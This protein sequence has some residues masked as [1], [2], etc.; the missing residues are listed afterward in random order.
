MYPRRGPGSHPGLFT[1]MYH[2]DAAYVSWVTGRNGVTTFDLY[3]RSAPF[4][5]A[6][7]LVAG[8]EAALEFVETFRYEPEELAFLARIRDYDAAFLDEL[9]ALRFTGDIMRCQRAASPSPM[10]RAAR[11]GALPRGGAGGGGAAPGDQPG[12]ADRHQGRAHRPRRAEP[13][14]LGVRLPPRAE[15]AGGGALVLHRRGIEHLAARGGLR[16]S[17]AGD[18]NRAARADPAFPHGGR[19]LPLRR[20]SFN[21]YTL[22]L[23]TYNPRQAIHTAIAVAQQVATTSAT[24]WRRC[25][26]IAATSWRTA[27][28]CAR[29]WRRR[30]WACAHPRERR[31]R[32]V[33]DRGSAGGGRGGGRLRGGDG[34]GRGRGQCRAWREGA[35][36][37]GVYKEVWYV[38]ENGGEHPKLK[39]AAEK[40]TWPGRKA[41]YRHPSGRKMSCSWRR[42]HRPPA[43]SGCC[44]R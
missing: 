11:H 6:Y 39:L 34:A 12:D 23:D 9:A 24:H 31:P 4:D 18:W 19:G 21:R 32:R 1:D 26:W 2:P 38:D 16:I 7:L 17:A 36:L 13:P 35:T 22:L 15:S 33:R 5:G 41:V 37:G 42:S 8:L 44:D 28:T 30:E 27:S 43:I 14:R 40:T 3:A 29:S 25:G 10:S 20:A